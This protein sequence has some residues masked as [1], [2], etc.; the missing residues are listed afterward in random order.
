MEKSEA[1]RAIIIKN[2]TFITP[3]KKI[4]EGFLIVKAGRIAEVGVGQP[5]EIT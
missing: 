1:G 5:T 2:G 3:F 4:E